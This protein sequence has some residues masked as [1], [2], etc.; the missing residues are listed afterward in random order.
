MSMS[1]ILGKAA[2]GFKRKLPTILMV[3]GSVTE[4][5]AVVTAVKSGPIALKAIDTTKDN[6]KKIKEVKEDGT[7]TYP[8][9]TDENGDVV[10]VTEDYTKSDYAKDLTI[11]YTRGAGRLIKSLWLPITLTFVSGGCYWAAYGMKAKALASVS[12][13]LATTTANFDNYRK[14]TIEELGKDK[15]KEFISGVREET[16]VDEDGKEHK[17]GRYI[18]DRDVDQTCPLF[19]TFTVRIDERNSS[20]RI[21]ATDDIHLATWLS[22]CEDSINRVFHSKGWIGADEILDIL[23]VSSQNNDSIDMNIAK[24]LGRIL[25]PEGDEWFSLNCWC[26]DD[27][28]LGERHLSVVRDRDGAIYLNLDLDPEPIIGRIPAKKKADIRDQVRKY[29]GLEK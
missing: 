21:N 9:G 18:L 11:E 4:I 6:I 20:Y 14:R 13:A 26:E 7:I 23:G 22:M 15:D 29:P 16:V 28:D 3:T 12:A 19:N 8:K 24:A 2:L 17:T 27:Y 25:S 1:L 5:A 10:T